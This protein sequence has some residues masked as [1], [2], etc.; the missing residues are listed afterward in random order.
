MPLDVRC[1]VIKRLERFCF[2]ESPCVTHAQLFLYNIQPTVTLSLHYHSEMYTLQN[3]L[4]SFHFSPLKIK[5]MLDLAHNMHKNIQCYWCDENT[6]CYLT[7]PAPSIPLQRQGT[8]P[9][10]HAKKWKKNPATWRL[11]ICALLKLQ[12]VPQ[13]MNHMIF[14]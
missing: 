8:V 10:L 14:A 1:L 11:K 12:G 6:R 4:I 13:N 2:R 9:P 3:T 5:L 7:E